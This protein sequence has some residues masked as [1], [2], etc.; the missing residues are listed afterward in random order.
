MPRAPPLQ[1]AIS[2]CGTSDKAGD[3]RESR[4]RG[5]EINRAGRWSTDSDRNWEMGKVA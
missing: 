1:L 5:G 4:R 2:P 3:G